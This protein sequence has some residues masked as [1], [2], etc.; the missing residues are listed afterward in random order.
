MLF[1]AFDLFDSKSERGDAERLISLPG[2][3]GKGS[4]PW[5]T[6]SVCLFVLGGSG[7]AGSF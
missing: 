3:D 1:D 7:A 6:M 4:S 2:C 5:G